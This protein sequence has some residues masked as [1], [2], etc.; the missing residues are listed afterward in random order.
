MR[1]VALTAALALSACGAPMM[2][3]D[4]TSRDGGA[5]AALDTGAPSE[6]GADGAYDGE[7]AVDGGRVDGG[8]GEVPTRAEPL[9]VRGVP[10]NPTR[11]ALGTVQ[12]VTESGTTTALFGSLGMTLVRAG[13]LL[14]RTSEVTAWRAAATVPAGIGTGAWIVAADGMGRVHRVRPDNALEFV[15]DRYGLSGQPVRWIAH[16]G[17]TFTGFA[18]EAGIA[19]AD[20]MTVRR[21]MEG[22]FVDFAA[23]A[24]RFAGVGADRVKVLN[25]MTG[26][27]RTWNVPG[28]TAVALDPD[29]RVV[30]AA[31]DVLWAERADGTIS[32]VFRAPAP[33]RSLAR[34]GPRVW[35]A[36]GRELGALSAGRV[37]LT[38]GAMIPADARLTAGT[39]DEVW[40]LTAGSP[41]RF[42][43]DTGTQTPEAIW[44]AVIQPIYAGSCARCHG[45]GQQ[46][47]DLSTLAGWTV[48]RAQLDARVVRQLGAP[49]PPDGRLSDG[50]RM[51]IGSWL[52]MR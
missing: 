29:G 25:A 31:G 38:G 30:V 21:F 51:T 8:A 19:V 3:P 27:L 12:A 16:G 41:L 2:N 28:V 33:V 40:A 34:S 44:R 45:P 43:I 49:M 10:Y 36:A 35:F 48:S 18:T 26:T 14:A 42:A 4:A 32:A 50:D 46:S 1:A 17:A 24:G 52:M 37:S 7:T 13:A 11:I 22:P 23:G 47:P 5:D 39:S 9:Y 6:V 20:G 15:G